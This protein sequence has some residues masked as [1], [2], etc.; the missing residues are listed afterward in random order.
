MAGPV[1]ERGNGGDI[2]PASMKLR[3]YGLAAL[4]VIDPAARRR[5]WLIVAAVSLLALLDLAGLFAVLALTVTATQAQR[6]ATQLEALTL[7]GPLPAIADLV[8][9]HTVS[10]SIAFLAICTVLLFVGK[11]LLAAWG[12]RRVMRFLARQDAKLT[13][14]LTSKLLRAP[15]SFHLRR[16]YIETMADVTVGAE[17][18]VMK[19]VAPL[20]LMC[21]EA[22]LILVI[23]IGLVV[24]APLVAAVSMVYF[25]GV[26]LSL[27]FLV[28]RRSAAAGVADVRYTRETMILLQWALGGYR[29]VVTR[30]AQGQFTAM[31]HSARSEGAQARAEFAFLGLVPR[32]FLEASLVIGMAL[33]YAVQLPFASPSQALAG[34]T[35]FAV[36]GFRLLPSMQ[37]LQASYA[38]IKGGQAFGE[39][40]LRLIAGLGENY[41]ADATSREAAPS[42]VLQEGVRLDNVS[43]RY[44]TA[45]DNALTNVTLQFDKG[46]TTALVGVSGSGKSTAID[47]L[48]GLLR[49]CSGEVLVDGVPLSDCLDSWRRSVGYVPQAVFLM[50]MSIRDNVTLG[51]TRDQV[52]D[53]KVWECLE[54]AA[55]RS[56]VEEV[57]RGLDHVLGDAGA[58]L[59]GGQRQRLGIARAL[60][61]DPAVLVMDEATSALDVETEAE[62]GQT[63]ADLDNDVTKIVV[64][65]RLSTIRH[66]D[67]VAFLADGCVVAQGTFDE[68]SSAVPDFARQVALSGLTVGGRS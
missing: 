3:R 23:C 31:V 18:L 48:L 28:G 37:R 27:N 8:G 34:L 2:E 68:V 53:R 49:P 9:V 45:D 15:L 1:S 25:S 60:Y 57:P 21:A 4:A 62:I 26:M 56:V 40:C 16:K 35:L 10:G 22:V 47:V 33:V 54:R 39:S 38:T 63:L 67:K 65:H 59:S 6:G 32:Y 61:L 13:S 30:N 14:R 66:A 58:G 17:S 43:Y 36:A 51:L 7:P 19:A 12:L 20:C 52:D 42:L 11:A 24:L 41:S 64:A 46:K 5:L 50:P 29:E 44:E 55:M